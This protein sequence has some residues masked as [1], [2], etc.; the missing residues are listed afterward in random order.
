MKTYKNLQFCSSI[1]TVIFVTNNIIGTICHLSPMLHDKSIRISLFG[2]CVCV[3][4]KFSVPASLTY[5]IKLRKGRSHNYFFVEHLS[6]FLK[7]LG[8]SLS[9]IKFVLKILSGIPYL[10]WG[11][12]MICLR[13]DETRH[14]SKSQP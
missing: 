9:D 5:R 11:H 3:F 7:G 10:F 2:F 12:Q 4:F 14:R 8:H 13:K 1:S 6:V